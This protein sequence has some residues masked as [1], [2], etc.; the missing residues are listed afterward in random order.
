MGTVSAGISGSE[1]GMEGVPPKSRAAGAFGGRN[2]LTAGTAPLLFA[3][4]PLLD[5][6][7]RNLAELPAASILMPGLVAASVVI[8]LEVTLLAL[9][10]SPHRVALALSFSAIVFFFGH[11]MLDRYRL[12]LGPL[13]DPRLRLGLWV[14]MTAPLA[15]GAALATG[16]GPATTAVL[17]RIGLVLI[18]MPVFVHFGEI[19]TRITGAMSNAG[20]VLPP[21]PIERR[22]TV[23]PD[24]D[25]PDIYVLLLDEYGRDDVLR[26]FYDYDNSPFLREL[27]SRGFVVARESYSPYNVTLL[28]VP[29]VLNFGYIHEMIGDP[30]LPARS[31]A[32]LERAEA[33]RLAEAAGYR[34][35]T[36]LP[37]QAKLREHLEDRLWPAVAEEDAATI[38]EGGFVH[39]ISRVTPLGDALSIVEG[40]RAGE[41][42]IR[43]PKK[44]TDTLRAL[45]ALPEI[46]ALPSR[47]FVYAHLM[48]PH[49]PCYFNADGT[50]RPLGKAG[51]GGAGGPKDIRAQYVDEI[52]GLNRHVLGA[53]DGIIERSATPPVI[54]IFG[55]HGPRPGLTFR[56]WREFTIDQLIDAG[57]IHLKE[58]LGILSAALLPGHAEAVPP[59]V[60]SI[61]LLREVFSF[62]LGYD[63][64]PLEERSFY[65]RIEDFTDYREV[66]ARL[67]PRGA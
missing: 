51:R 16:V 58:Q 48:S 31:M 56:H 11:L 40:M 10:R 61:N 42:E 50:V 24:V 45:E 33:F 53:I 37:Y 27:E 15:W 60:S 63:L 66:T 34:V 62:Y 47:T 5:L 30:V 59:T 7:L 41:A 55:D 2:W 46:A 12:I 39:L 20:G 52:Q 32:T 38:L 57:N 8:V 4:F 21:A 25:G 17:N 43:M 14:G 22:P 23:N 35:I 18:V 28:T 67:P 49:G 36:L 29:S 54:L 1:G 44:A 65:H 64:P 3:L 13:D 26:E 19:R 9:S 6:Y